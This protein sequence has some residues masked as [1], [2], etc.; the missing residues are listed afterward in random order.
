MHVSLVNIILRYWSA[1]SWCVVWRYL[2]TRSCHKR[3]HDFFE[4]L[5]LWASSAIS[6]LWGR[7]QSNMADITESALR[8]KYLMHFFQRLCTTIKTCWIEI[9]NLGYNARFFATHTK[10]DKY[11]KF[12]NEVEKHTWSRNKN[13]MDASLWEGNL[14]QYAWCISSILKHVRLLGLAE[15]NHG[16]LTSLHRIRSDKISE[17]ERQVRK[18]RLLNVHHVVTS[19]GYKIW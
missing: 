17:K 10:S 3:R 5:L 16:Y 7:H 2:K 18:S 14:L 8:I 11:I 19:H 13:L 15:H 1:E 9:I 4:I 6:A 12:N